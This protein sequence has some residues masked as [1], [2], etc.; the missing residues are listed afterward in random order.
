VDPR[1]QLGIARK[2]LPRLV[3]G[4][5]VS[6]IAAFGV[7][8]VQ[9]RMYEANATLI[10]GQALQA[11]NP[12][13][14]QLTVSQRLSATYA[15]VATKRP[16]LEAVIA[17]MHLDQTPEELLKHVRATVP[18]DSTL[19]TITAEDPSPDR[20][21]A[22]ANTLSELLIA[23]SP[24]IQGV[25][26]D[27]QESIRAQLTATLEQI[28]GAQAE[29]ERIS[30]LESPRPADL[31][32]LETLQGRLVTLRSTY[33]A[34]VSASAQSASNLLTL[35]EPA[36]APAT[37]SSPRILLNTA[38]AALIGLLLVAVIAAIVEYLDDGVKSAEDVHDLVGLSTL[39]TVARMSIDRGRP[40]F[41]RLATLITP[42]SGVAEAYRILRSNIEFASVDA[43]IR[44]LVVT[45]ARP[46]EGKTVS[47]ANLA[48]AFAQAERKTILVDADL[49][50]PSVH[51][52][53]GIGNEDGLT[54]ML[55]DDTVT[56]AA[57]AKATEQAN[58]RIVTAGPLPPN[59]AEL[60]GSQ[61]MRKTIDKLAAAADIVIFDTPPVQVV[62]DA[63][64]LSSFL[65]AAILV[66]DA[67]RSR[68]GAV[69]EAR[70]ALARANAKV[71]GVILNRVPE[72]LG[73]VDHGYYHVN[74]VEEPVQPRRHASKRSS[75]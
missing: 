34:L 9:P 7:S 55:R 60:L 40:D 15:A 74:M 64:V 73:A 58:L 53:F 3:A 41:Y 28:E 12:D 4:A 44:T 13:V 33:A 14:N 42:R 17:R 5:I 39:G 6:A 54:T 19:L 50:Q 63:A 36:V 37:P 8:S 72:G 51:N 32:S 16:T 22:I 25:Q 71:L 11:L 26:A 62:I 49:R 65:D 70:E 67:G 2:W 38:L 66:V 27:L 29:V 24:A 18:P 52:M 56:V 31:A 69:R 46:L 10:V 75:S 68:R 23:S 59:P 45:S 57:V 1:R 43:P 47:A 48:V 35:I 61:R 21:A 30:G 20:A